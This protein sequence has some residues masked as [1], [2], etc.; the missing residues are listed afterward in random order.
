MKPTFT[1]NQYA[2]VT[3][4]SKGLGRAFAFALAKRKI[5]T[6]LV[7]LPGE[8]LSDLSVKISE[9]SNTHSVYF[10]TDLTEKA[11]IVSL[12]ARV[13]KYYDV[14]ILINNAGLGGTKEFLKADLDYIN[15]IIQ[16]NVTATSL[17]T[18]QLLKN[19]LKQPNGYILNVSSISAFSPTGYKTVYPASKVFVNYFTRGLCH[20]LSHT[21]VFASVVNPGPMETN[22]EVKQRIRR[23]GFI[24]RL[25][26]LPVEEVA[27][28]SL[29]RLFRRS[30]L[31]LLNKS[32]MIKRLLMRIIPVTIRIPLITRITKREIPQK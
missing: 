1:N 18:H 25:G 10:E 29:N 13:N 27:E 9:A 4:A 3:G 31:I 15:T 21:N 14:C 7:G 8:G 23:Q 17:L 6:I 2:L 5:N 19:L 22:E 20:E 28:I 12:A 26:L 11:N 16:L 24:G 30:Q 32:N